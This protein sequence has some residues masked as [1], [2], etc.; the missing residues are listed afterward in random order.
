MQTIEQF[1]NYLLAEKG[2]SKATVLTYRASLTDLWRFCQRLDEQL[3]WERLDKDVLRRWMMA[4]M[5]QG[6]TARTVNRKMSSVRSFYRYLLRM[7]RVTVDPTETL[8]N[9]KIQKRLP[10]F[11]RENEMD[12]LFDEVEFGEG[13]EAE[14]DR[15]ILLTFYSTGIRLSEL[16][17]LTVKDVDL[18]AKE[19][20]VLGK[21]NKQRIV[22]F[23][24]EL[25][26]AFRSFLTI[27]GAEVSQDFNEIFLRTNGKPMTAGEVR[28]VVKKYLS[29]VTNQ[30]KRSPH[31][32]RHTYA[33]VML[34]NGADLEAVKELLGHESVSTTEVYTHTTF[35]ELKKAYEQAHPRA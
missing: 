27:R 33:T 35:A 19:L 26:E 24:L 31:V 11:V 30:Q 12:R 20:K 2:Y 5:E 8:K 28:A 16:L 1:M 32:L 14:R 9:P 10:T 22:P 3:T 6:V 4:D 29:C 25:A 21:R 18:C 17:G 7:Q 34:N 15:L 23:G 13:Y